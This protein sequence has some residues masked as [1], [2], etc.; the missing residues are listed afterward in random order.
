ML[1]DQITDR[2]CILLVYAQAYAFAPP[3]TTI[4]P[5]SKVFTAKCQRAA[6]CASPGHLPGV[7]VCTCMSRIRAFLPLREPFLNKL[8]I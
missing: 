7:N 2:A 5:L 3:I 8:S 1:S 6:D 4:L